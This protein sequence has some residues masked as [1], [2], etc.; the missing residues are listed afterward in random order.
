VT[1][2]LWPE[3]EEPYLTALQAASAFIVERFDPV[4]LLV[5][6]TILRGNPG[7]TSDLDLQ[8]IHQQPWRQRVQR[9][10]G[11]VPV[12]MFVNPPHMIEHYFEVE[13]QQGRPITAHM[14]ATGYSLYDPDGIIARFRARAVDVLESGPP[15]SEA[16]LALKRYMATTWLDDAEDVA[17]ENPALCSAFLFNAVEDA[18]RYRFWRDRLWQPRNKDLLRSLSDL[19]PELHALL[20]CFY[21]ARELTQRVQTARRVLQHSVG[22]TGFFEWESD[23]EPV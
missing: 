21:R 22:E 17:G 2:H 12:E 20:L 9:K 6:G 16:D 7:P 14:L 5:S 4:G 19:D 15:V 18:L 11:G 8:V 23:P 13:S 3:L 10:F 1:I